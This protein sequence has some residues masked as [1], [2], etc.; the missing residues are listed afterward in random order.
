MAAGWTGE[1]VQVPAE[2]LPEH[3]RQPFDFR[4]E[5]ATATA[6]IREELSYGEPVGREEA[7]KRTVEWEHSQPGAFDACKV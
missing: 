6:R 4:Y 5:L 7:L 1:V 3:L 2:R